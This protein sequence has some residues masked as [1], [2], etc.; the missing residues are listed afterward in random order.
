MHNA[1]TAAEPFYRWV[2]INW[3]ERETSTAARWETRRRPWGNG[4]SQRA[5]EKSDGSSTAEPTIPEHQMAAAV[6]YNSK[7]GAMQ[8]KDGVVSPSPGLI[9]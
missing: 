7:S 8:A 9:S 1:A 5:D 3:E 6:Q 2:S 4:A